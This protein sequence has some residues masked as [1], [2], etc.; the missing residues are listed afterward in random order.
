MFAMDDPIVSVANGGSMKDSVPLA[1]LQR[2][3]W[4]N[5]IVFAIAVA[6][7]LA[8]VSLCE[9]RFHLSLTRA[10]LPS[11]GVFGVCGL[12]GIRELLP[13]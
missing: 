13:V 12:L 11:L 3:A 9:W 6:L 1:P 5:L 7:Y 10:A 2:Y 8:A 4:F